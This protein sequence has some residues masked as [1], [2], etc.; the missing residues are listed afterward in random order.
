M[1]ADPIAHHSDD[2]VEIFFNTRDAPDFLL[3]YSGAATLSR[4][5]L[6]SQSLA[7]PLAS[8]ESTFGTGALAKFLSIIQ[9]PDLYA[10]LITIKVKC[11][12]CFLRTFRPYCEIA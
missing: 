2:V 3:I 5:G 6:L 9:Y 11:I 10:Q 12:E 1:T 4:S 7:A 8:L